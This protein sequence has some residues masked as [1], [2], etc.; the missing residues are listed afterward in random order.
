[1]SKASCCR[2]IK[3]GG[4]AKADW[5]T[6]TALPS[7]CCGEEEEEEEE[8]EE[9]PGWGRGHTAASNVGTFHRVC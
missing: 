4:M 7:S 5:T 8:E 6:T 3:L 1:M 9:V 2:V